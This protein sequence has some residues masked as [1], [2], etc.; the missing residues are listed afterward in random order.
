MGAFH[1]CCNF[2]DIFGRRFGDAGLKDLLVEN[3][4]AAGSITGVLGGNH[5]NRAVRAHKI[6]HE[7]LLRVKWADFGSWLS[8]HPQDA[9]NQQALCNLLN[10]LHDAVS[11]DTISRLLGSE[12][13][14]QMLTAYDKY[15]NT[16]RG[17]TAE[18]WE[19]YI[20]LTE[21]LLHFIRSTRTGNWELHKACLSKMLPWMFAY[22]HTNYSRYLTLYLW[23]MV[24]LPITHPSLEE[25]MNQGEFAVQR[26]EGKAFSQIPVDQTI[27]QTVNRDSKTQVAV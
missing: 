12:H 17:P 7:A 10:E 18:L 16:S 25:S 21:L 5:Y 19:S 1:L 15:T 11:C 22:D 8:E 9:F 2:L 3:V 27:E 13:Y 23:D 14:A 26:S 4:V 6:M 24:Q 20:Y